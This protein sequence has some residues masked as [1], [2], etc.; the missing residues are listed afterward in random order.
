MIHMRSHL[1]PVQVP[2]YLRHMLSSPLPPVKGRP[3]QRCPSPA[4]RPIFQQ[5]APVPTQRPYSPPRPVQQEP[6]PEVDTIRQ[7]ILIQ[8]IVPIPSVDK[9]HMCIHLVMD[10]VI[11]V[12]TTTHLSHIFLP[13]V[14]K[15][16][17]K[18][19]IEV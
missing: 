6:Q 7:F 8:L 11:R 12:P 1:L 16:I 2:F 17:I 10:L 18:N 15:M 9:C 5:P 14:L 3:P 4:P 13:H 19:S